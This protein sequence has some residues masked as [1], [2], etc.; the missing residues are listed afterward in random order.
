MICDYYYCPY[1]EFSNPDKTANFFC[2]V[3]FAEEFRQLR[4][5]I[6]PSGEERFI[7]SLTRCV[8]YEAKGGKSR[9]AFCKVAGKLYNSYNID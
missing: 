4:E 1:T 5:R 9:S 8:K 6:F 7:H 2:K 3:Y